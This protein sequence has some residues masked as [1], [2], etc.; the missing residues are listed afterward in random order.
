MV[1]Q[2]L[3]QRLIIKDWSDFMRFRTE[4]KNS[5]LAHNKSVQTFTENARTHYSSEKKE[6]G[7]ELHT[8]ETDIL[9]AINDRF[10]YGDTQ[11]DK[12]GYVIEFFNRSNKAKKLFHFQYEE[13][14]I[15]LKHLWEKDH[16]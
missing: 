13:N 11:K 15:K 14:Y 2:I 12:S 4:K 10:E 8:N 9:K 1:I 16:H 3:N 6:M 7:H 5:G